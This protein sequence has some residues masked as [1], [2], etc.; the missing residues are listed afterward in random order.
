M[1]FKNTSGIKI[2]D[3]GV[4]ENFIVSQNGVQL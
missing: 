4:I 2:F 3:V 1:A